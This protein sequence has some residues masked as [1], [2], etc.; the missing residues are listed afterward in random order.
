MSVEAQPRLGHRC[1]DQGMSTGRLASLPLQGLAFGSRLGSTWLLDRGLRGRFRRGFSDRLGCWLL[2]R[3]LL[4]GRSLDRRLL[5]RHNGGRLGWRIGRLGLRRPRLDQARRRKVGMGHRVGPART[6][7]PRPWTDRP[8]TEY[9][10][11]AP[12]Q[13]EGT[14]GRRLRPKGWRGVTAHRQHPQS[15][16]DDRTRAT[17]QERDAPDGDTWPPSSRC[18][19]HAPPRCGPSRRRGAREAAPTSLVFRLVRP[20]IRSRYRAHGSS[21]FGDSTLTRRRGGRGGPCLPE[22]V[23]RA[24]ELLRFVPDGDDEGD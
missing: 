5:H 20:G 14:V 10:R 6:N 17:P 13:P 11:N 3:R 2:R 8:G 4:D 19:R 9:P 24:V 22:A 7:R 16:P 21:S 1:V 12:P 18:W 15:A 23:Q